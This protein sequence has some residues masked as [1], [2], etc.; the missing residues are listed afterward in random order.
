MVSRATYKM[1]FFALDIEGN[2][3]GV[4]VDLVALG[5][6]GATYASNMI[7]RVLILTKGA[8]L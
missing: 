5:F 8:N 7:L 2:F 1:R 4:R 3:D 6:G